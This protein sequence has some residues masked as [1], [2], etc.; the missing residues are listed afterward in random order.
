MYGALDDTIAAIASPPSAALRGVIR[1]SGPDTVSCLARCVRLAGDQPL[2]ACRRAARRDGEILLTAPPLALPC[3]IYL[4]P[5]RRSYTLQ[6]VAELHTFGSPPLLTAVLTTLC[7][8]GAR[9]AAPGEFTLRAFLAGRLD[10]TQA[11]AV[12][13][14]IDADTEQ[15]LHV[16][17]SQLAGGLATPLQ[18][19]R[20]ELLDL[21]A[22][23]EAGLDFV[24]EDITLIAPAAVIDRLERAAAAAAALLAQL[25]AR[26]DRGDQLQVVLCGAPNV[27]KSSLLNALVGSDAALVSALPGTTRDYVTRRFRWE[28]VDGL[29]VDTAGL[30]DVGH[31]DA[32]SDAAQ[33]VTRRQLSAAALELLCLDASRLSEGGPAEPAARPAGRARL[34]VWTKGDLI[35]PGATPP[36]GTLLTSSRTGQ[37]VAEL[38]RAVAAVLADRTGAELGVVAATAARCEACLRAVVE[39]LQAAWAI[40]VDC[41]GDELV[42]AELREALDQLG[43]VVGAVFT[44]DLLDRIFSRFCIGK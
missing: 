38:R 23:I 37:G 5:T 18:A 12:L 34:V 17:L 40:A 8:A 22:D 42:A 31:G 39:H 6:P 25:T 35:P 21:L 44:E 43:Q 15:E 7:R 1:V 2:T 3:Q 9:L 13:G 29:L 24:E 20:G 19:L 41:A 32:L 14:V 10:L 16:A 33:E 26:A 28:G 27:G 30:S 36:P 11:E 4:W